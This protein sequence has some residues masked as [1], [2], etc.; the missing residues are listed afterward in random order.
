LNQ[1]LRRLEIPQIGTFFYKREGKKPETD[2][3]DGFTMIKHCDKKSHK[4]GLSF[5]RMSTTE[6][7]FAQNSG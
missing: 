5:S 4:R 2:G 1:G 6:K 3:L 7:R